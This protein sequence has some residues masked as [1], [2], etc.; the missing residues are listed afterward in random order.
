MDADLFKLE[1]LALQTLVG[2]DTALQQGNP[3]APTY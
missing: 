2:Q 3:E 1:L